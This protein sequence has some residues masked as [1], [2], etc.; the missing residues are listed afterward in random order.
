MWLTP[1]GVRAR[2]SALK[3]DALRNSLSYLPNLT[4]LSTFT[5][6]SS[7][8]SFHFIAVFTKL[9]TPLMPQ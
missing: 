8:T 1:V 6:S 2:E 7:E 9:Q 3:A 5:F 4:E